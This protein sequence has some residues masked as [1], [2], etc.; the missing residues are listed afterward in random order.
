MRQ[1]DI[2]IIHTPSCSHWH[3]ARERVERLA[4]DKGLAVAITETTIVD[5]EDAVARHFPG[6]PTILIDGR[7]VAPPPAASPADYGLG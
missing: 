2:E 5:H 1:I 7:D 6:S 4:R 3:I